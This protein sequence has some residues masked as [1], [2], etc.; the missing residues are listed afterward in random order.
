[1]KKL[2]AILFATAILCGCS[3]KNS[4]SGNVSTVAPNYE[5]IEAP[6]DESGIIDWA[7]PYDTVL[8]DFRKTAECDDTARFSIYDMNDDRLPELIISYGEAGNRNFL[9][10]TIYDNA[11]TSLGNYAG[12]SEC[13]GR[14]CG[15]VK[16]E[17]RHV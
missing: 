9:L 16:I 6:T 17:V 13:G 4:S 12:Y 7:T 10:Y 1:M 14:G 3:S 2:A 11:L 5:G 8:Q 15:R